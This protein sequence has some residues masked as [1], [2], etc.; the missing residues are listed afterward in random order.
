MIRVLLVLLVIGITIY[1]L[2]GLLQKPARGSGSSG[3]GKGG[4]TMIPCDYCRLHVPRSEALITEE[5]RFCSEAHRHAWLDD[6]KR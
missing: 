4:E 6:G 2:R 5:G 1:A 3:T